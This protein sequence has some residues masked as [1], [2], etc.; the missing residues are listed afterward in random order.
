MRRLCWTGFLAF[1]VACDDTTGIDR[2]QIDVAVSPDRIAHGDTAT[3]IVRYTNRSPF[4]VEIRDRCVSPFEIANA[5]G[6]VVAGRDPLICTLEI[7]P[8]VVLLP[9]E[10]LER[11]AL[12][13]GYRRRPVGDTWI[14]EPVPAGLYRVYGRLEGR[15]ST[16][17]TIEVN[18][19]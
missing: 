13:T 17:D 18:G 11:R 6:E 15:L 3:I 8:P 9:F 7:R 2:V 16:P 1:L 10:S 12:W 14:T 5:Q 4:A 19:M